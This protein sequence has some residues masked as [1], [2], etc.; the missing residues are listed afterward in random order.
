MVHGQRYTILAKFTEA[1]K[2]TLRL[3]SV[4]DPQILFSTAIIDFQIVGKPQSTAPSVPF[5]NERGQN[6]SAAAIFYDGSVAKP[7][8]PAVVPATVD[9][10][11]KLTMR[12]GTSTNEWAFNTTARVEHEAATP[13]LFSPQPGLQDNHTITVPSEMSWV[14]Y[15]MQIPSGQPAHPV[16]IHGRHFHVLGSG[17]GA[18]PWSSVAEASQHLP[19]GT[20]NLVNPQLR[21]TYYTPG[22][23]G[24]LAVRRPSDN[25]GVWLVHCHIMSHLQG[26]MS[27]VIQDGT[28]GG[29]FVPPAYR[30]YQCAPQT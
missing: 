10:T 6:V 12:I 1:K 20:F 7:Y 22:G 28:D 30:G 17:S 23:E 27:V 15:I 8:P 13:L 24:W 2:Y 18:F 19:A 5:I 25:E 3:S 4:I 26:G 9:A 14:D 11:Y 21:D 16:H 29:I